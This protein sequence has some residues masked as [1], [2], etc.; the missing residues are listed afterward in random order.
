MSLN[1]DVRKARLGLI[2]VL[3]MCAAAVS[4]AIFF[5]ASKSD[6]YNFELEYEG[7]VKDI[8]T[9]VQWEVQYNFALMQQMS[10]AL[11]SAAVAAGATFPNFTM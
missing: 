4:I 6:E 2:V 7:F 10:A 5:F 1:T 9:L 8:V 3:V 11:T